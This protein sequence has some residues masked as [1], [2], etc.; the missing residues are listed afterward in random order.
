MAHS[1]WIK[2][3]RKILD[4]DGWLEKPF[5]KQRAWIDLL[6]LAQHETHG[7]FRKGCVYKSKRELSDRWGW[8]VGKVTRFLDELKNGTQIRT[9]NRSLNGTVITIV[10]WDLYQHSGTPNGTPNGTQNGMTNGN[11]Y[12]NVRKEHTASE[13]G[14]SAPSLAIVAS[15]GIS[16]RKVKNADGDW[17]MERIKDGE[18]N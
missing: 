13:G 7:E 6:L 16:Y 14:H 8:S 15:D 11:Q 18:G 2:L 12:K 5:D 10:N 3:H 17:I 9:L 4:S 1:G